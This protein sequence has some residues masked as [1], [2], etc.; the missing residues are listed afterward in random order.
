MCNDFFGHIC[1][2]VVARGGDFFGGN[3]TE[4]SAMWYDFC[5]VI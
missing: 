1:K 2:E 5:E 3:Y 4:V